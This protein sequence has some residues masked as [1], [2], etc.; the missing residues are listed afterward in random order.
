M[1]TCLQGYEDSQY[2]QDITIDGETVEVFATEDHRK[3]SAQGQ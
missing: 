2:T 3:V 1:R